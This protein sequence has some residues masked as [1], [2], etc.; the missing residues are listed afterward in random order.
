MPFQ[1]EEDLWAPVHTRYTSLYFLVKT[2]P[3]VLGFSLIDSE[4]E[5]HEFHGPFVF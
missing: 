5:S 1:K 3:W 2:K 4:V